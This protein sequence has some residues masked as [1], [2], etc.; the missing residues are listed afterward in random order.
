M[1][2]NQKQDPKSYF[3]T[4]GDAQTGPQGKIFA[5]LYSTLHNLRFDMQHGYVC[6]KL[7]LDPSGP[8][9][10]WP[11]PKGSSKFRMCSSSPHPYGYHL[12]KF[13]ESSLNGLGAMVWHYRWTDGQTDR[14]YKNIPS[15]SSKSVGII[16]FLVWQYVFVEKKENFIWITLLPVTTMYKLFLL[17]QHKMAKR[18]QLLFVSKWS[19]YGR[20]PVQHYGMSMDNQF[21]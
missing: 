7:I 10:P 18:D 13:W 5:P 1:G 17:W 9:P 16:T 15:F 12:W 2:D 14:G 11:C 3:L 4:S 20:L 8:H 19:G 21:S 6:I